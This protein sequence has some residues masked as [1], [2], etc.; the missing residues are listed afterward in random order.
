[1]TK[2]FSELTS[3]ETGKWNVKLTFVEIYNETIINLLQPEQK[4]ISISDTSCRSVFA[5]IP[6]TQ[7][8]RI[9]KFM[10]KA[11]SVFVGM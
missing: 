6:S 7:I 4:G 8:V 2:V 9:M 1:M 3:Q 5:R 10:E 11:A